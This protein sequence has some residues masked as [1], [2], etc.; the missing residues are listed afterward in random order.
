VTFVPRQGSTEGA[1]YLV[2]IASNYAESRSEL[3]VL[4]AKRMEE[5]ARVILPVQAKQPGHGVWASA[6]ELPLDV[7]PATNQGRDFE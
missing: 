6:T 5:L 1:G 4:D 3:I 2:G 7:E